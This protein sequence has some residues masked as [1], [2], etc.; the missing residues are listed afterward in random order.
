[1]KILYIK[2]ENFIG[3]QAAM[4]VR[5]VYFDFTKI[6]KPIIQIYGK[7][8]C[9]KTVLLQQ[10]HPYSSINLSGDERSDLSLI[11]PKETGI[12]EIGYEVN[13]KVYTI[14]HTYTP[15]KTSHTISSSLLC[16][17][18]ELNPSGG[19]T[20][21]NELVEQI[22]GINKYSYQLIINGT[23]LQS[24]GTMSVTQRKNLMNK[25]MGIDIY[26]KIHKLAT[27]DYRYTNKLITSLNNTKEFVLQTYGSYENMC[28]IHNY[29]KN[30]VELLEQQLANMKS[31]LDTLQGKISTIRQQNPHQ[32][33]NEI[34]QSLAAYKNVVESIGS[35]DNDTYDKLVQKQIDL[36]NLI[37]ST[38]NERS[39]VLRDLDD[40]YKKKE[41][42]ESTLMNSRRIAADYN[43]MLNTQRG[44]EDRIN[45]IQ[46]EEFTSAPSQ[47]FR[48]M[49]SQAQSINSLCKDIKTCLNQTLLNMFAEMLE[50]NIDVSSFLVREGAALMDSEKEKSA[51]SRVR[52]TINSVEGEIHDECKHTD[53]LYWRTYEVLQTYFKSYQTATGTNLTQYDI[54]QFEHAHKCVQMIRRMCDLDM[55]K[56]IK[57]MFQV[58][59]I[60]RNVASGLYG[61]D[62][63]RITYLMEEAAKVELKQQLTSQLNDITKSIENMKSLLLPTGDMDEVISGIDQKIQSLKSDEMRLTQTISQLEN[64]LNVNANQ[65]SMVSQVKN[66]NVTELSM[67]SKRLQEL[68]NTL[69]ESEVRYNELFSQCSE[70]N[71]RLAGLRNDLKR[72]E[73]AHNQYDSTVVEVEKH[74]LSN[75]RYNIIAEATSSTKG[76]PVIAIREKVE[77]ALYLTNRLLDVMYDKEIQMLKPVIDETSFSLPFRSGSNIS[78]DIRYGSQSESTLLSLA[79]SLSL[80]SSL[81]A[82]NVP[83]IDEMDAALDAEMRDSFLMMLQEIMSVLKME[84]MFIIS[85]STQPGAY[86]HAVHVINISEEIGNLKE[87]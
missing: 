42:I 1:M 57:S 87:D 62:T 71:T 50:N 73:D 84:Q 13:G 28:T 40:M 15:T 61:I 3:V 72:V 76:K 78:S 18:K 36:N 14:T 35:F 75:K 24:F 33:L 49:L 7:N 38:K 83:L 51:I 67:R 60:V 86:D 59:R 16:D 46:I 82:Y 27:D 44:L 9:G 29:K 56:E 8:R 79:L 54:E 22:F 48:S 6:Q 17:G 4:G 81:T 32:E 74:V 20:I 11:I 53:C 41:D 77:D 66:I 12:K 65:R 63:D 37:S 70:V 39:M 10:L 31:E 55:A 21:F 2:L 85:H 23:N 80:A 69:D 30:E 19:V 47:H 5:S 25:A 45:N 26:D 43:D 34:N 64:D 58:D 52:D 68:V